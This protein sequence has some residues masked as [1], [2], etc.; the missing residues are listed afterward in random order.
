M[1]AAAFLFTLSWLF[2]T[3]AR[4]TQP[5]LQNTDGDEIVF[6]EARF[7]LAPSVKQEEIAARLNGIPALSQANA[8]FWNWLE[9]APKS[10][11]KSKA[12]A[13]A[14]DTTMDNGP[15]VLGNVELKGR[16]LHLSANSAERA[17][18]GTALIQQALGDLIRT[19]LTNIRTV[20]QLTADQPPSGSKTSRSNIDPEIAERSIHEYLD[21]HYLETLDQPVK[22]L[23]N[24]TPRQAVK[25]TAGRQKVV[26]WL[27]YIENQTAR[28]PDPTQPMATYSL[29]WMWK[30][31]GVH[32]LRR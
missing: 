26:E 19:P 2:D 6:H 24:K 32:D 16:F 22:M 21:R 27:K 15:L 14:I 31:L 5:R 28:Q 8:K 3:L 12:T 30:E 10:S 11:K 20:E 23:G 1:Q 18:K 25:T 4:V 13:P 29:E 7:P 17:T 9:E